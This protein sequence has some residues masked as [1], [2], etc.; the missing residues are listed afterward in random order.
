MNTRSQPLPVSRL[1][2]PLLNSDI[3]DPRS[4]EAMANELY[5]ALPGRSSLANQVNQ[6]QAAGEA[7]AIPAPPSPP[8]LTTTAAPSMP[9]PEAGEEIPSPTEK[10]AETDAFSAITQQ[11]YAQMSSASLDPAMQQAIAGL[12]SPRAPDLPPE[13]P[14]APDPG[15]TPSPQGETGSPPFSFLAV[16]AG[17]NLGLMP[18]PEAG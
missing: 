6:A 11:L 17:E 14:N 15:A 8:G 7:M 16:P 13:F 3:F 9:A 4:V 1:P 10:P 2:E 12:D 18:A 5:G